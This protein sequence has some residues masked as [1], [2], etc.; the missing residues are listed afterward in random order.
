M[1]AIENF[2]HFNVQNFSSVENVKDVMETINNLLQIIE[3][4]FGDTYENSK[5]YWD[6]NLKWDAIQVLKGVI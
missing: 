2:K 4:S 1:E 5:V 3:G 6:K